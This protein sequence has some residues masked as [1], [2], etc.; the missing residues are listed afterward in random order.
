MTGAILTRAP[1][2]K[3]PF[4][5]GTMKDGWPTGGAPWPAAHAAGNYGALVPRKRAQAAVPGPVSLLRVTNSPQHCQRWGVRGRGQSWV[6]G[7]WREYKSKRNPWPF[8]FVVLAVRSIFVFVC[9]CFFFL[10]PALVQTAFLWAPAEKWF[11][12]WQPQS[13]GWCSTPLCGDPVTTGFHCQAPWGCSHFGDKAP[14]LLEP[15]KACSELQHVIAAGSSDK[16]LLCGVPGGTLGLVRPA[17]CPAFTWG[18]NAPFSVLWL[19][20]YLSPFPFPLPGLPRV[21]ITDSGMG[22]G[23]HRGKELPPR[24]L[25]QPLCVF[26]CLFFFQWRQQISLQSCFKIRRFPFFVIFIFR[27]LEGLSQAEPFQ[28]LVL[29][30]HP[31]SPFYGCLESNSP[32]LQKICSLQN[33]V[34]FWNTELKGV[35]WL[36]L[37]AE[38]FHPQV[39]V[40]QWDWHVLMAW[41]N[42]VMQSYC[43]DWKLQGENVLPHFA[44]LSGISFWGDG[45]SFSPSLLPGLV[46]SAGFTDAVWGF[47]SPLG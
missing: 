34:C 23:E 43:T 32:I 19:W 38:C 46:D 17:R 41:K 33:Q 31:C 13:Q 29:L 14:S 45:S 18:T 11:R 37:E 27:H 28:S 8:S 25:S 6:A 10:A 40:A 26:V 21:L 1:F 12:R 5:W 44:F 22:R 36:F 4:C 20:C 9:C 3:L 15:C 39:T 35:F 16:A 7:Q 42:Q 30:C 2:S 47:S 24:F